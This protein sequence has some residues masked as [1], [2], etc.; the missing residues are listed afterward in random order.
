LAVSNATVGRL[1]IVATNVAVPASDPAEYGRWAAR[2]QAEFRNQILTSQDSPVELLQ[3]TNLA[4]L[5]WSGGAQSLPC[6]YLLRVTNGSQALPRGF[7]WHTTAGHPEGPVVRLN[8]NQV[9]NEDWRSMRVESSLPGFAL[10]LDNAAN[11]GRDFSLVT[12]HRLYLKGHFNTQGGGPYAAS[13]VTGDRVH[14]V[15][16]EW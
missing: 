1:A 13:L 11:L 9:R 7:S 15:P 8:Y 14:V 5:T 12:P 16:Q 6:E 10:L 4:G 3:A 2:R